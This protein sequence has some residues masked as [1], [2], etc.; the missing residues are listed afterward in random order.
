MTKNIIRLSIGTLI[1]LLIPLAL[2]IRDGNVP[3]VGWNWSPGDFVF[4]F[5]MIFGTGLA[6]LFLTRKAGTTTYYKV[7]VGITLAI[8]FALVWINA[9]VGLFR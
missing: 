2:T 4:A 7:A 5:I 9:A 8:V 3:N 1:F 6:Y